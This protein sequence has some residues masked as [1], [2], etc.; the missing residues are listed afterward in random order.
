MCA[1]LLSLLA[2]CET[3]PSELDRDLVILYT[4]DIRGE[5]DGRVGFAGLAAY[6]S[7]MERVKNHVL[8]A[9]L[10][11]ALQG[12]AL[13]AV[14][15]GEYPVELMN[16][17]GY[18]VCAV[19]ERDFAFGTENL[20]ARSREATFT[21]LACNLHDTGGNA[22]FDGYKMYEYNGVRIAFVGITSPNAQT[23]SS[24][25]VFR[26]E[27]GNPLY[28]FSAENNGKD[29]YEAVQNTVDAARRDG[30]RYVIALAHLGSSAA[31]SPYRAS[32][33]IKNTEGIDVFLDGDGTAAATEERIG[34]RSGDGILLV[35]AKSGLSGF[36]KLTVG[37][38]GTIRNEQITS[39]EEKHP[40]VLGTVSS[41][42]T[43]ARERMNDSLAT[44]WQDLIATDPYDP[45][46][47]LVE[48]SET[49]L[50][51]LIAD[52]VRTY[53]GADAALIGA[54]FLIGSLKAGEIS[55]NDLLRILPDENRLKIVEVTGEVL[56]DAL[57]HSVRLAP[58]G[59]TG[60][61]QISGLTFALDLSV[62]STV[63]ADDAGNFHGILGERRVS[64]VVIGGEP[65]DPEK[66]YT[67]ALPAPLLENGVGG[68][69]M[70]SGAR[71]ISSDA[72]TDLLAT[73]YY[74][75]V[76]R[77]GA[78]D[79]TYQNVRGDGRIRVIGE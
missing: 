52:A 45:G 71:V 74:L 37:A 13:A 62:L 17:V 16:A 4:S 32:D 20:L 67:L 28:D 10:G 1:L 59:C 40:G 57:E 64:D 15:R 7:E 47:R 14:S 72:G 48:T 43:A 38:D 12:T 73:L 9:D 36:G 55:Y 46:E 22:V 5:A 60:F 65:L 79:D 44:V 78:V 6:K 70:F 54:E 77:S 11:N 63:N 42:R 34:N 26:D 2:G 50:G 61:L 58:E 30:A 35:S 31:A 25:G 3:G 19:G 76:T 66:T 33:V 69:T 51:D 23:V 8:V 56:L 27:S 29:L 41:V 39:V 75:T 24:P 68:Y 53:T 21:Y 49:N 18:D